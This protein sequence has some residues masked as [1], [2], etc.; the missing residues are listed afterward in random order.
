MM[1]SRPDLYGDRNLVPIRPPFYKNYLI[2]NLYH[3]RLL[4][5]EQ[6]S[7]VRK[8]GSALEDS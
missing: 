2:G 1:S 3:S 8:E 6:R 7:P 4:T 5:F